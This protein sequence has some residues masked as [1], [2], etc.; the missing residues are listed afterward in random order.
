MSTLRPKIWL[1]DQIINLYVSC[2]VKININFNTMRRHY[3][4]NSQLVAMLLR[5]AGCKCSNVKRCSKKVI[6][7]CAFSLDK[8]FVATSTS[9]AHWAYAVINMK[10]K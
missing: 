4:F 6:G 10:T 5:E 8:I 7:K 9:D 2:L 3:F 1:N